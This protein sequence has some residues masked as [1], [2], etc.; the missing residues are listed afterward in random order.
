[1]GLLCSEQEITEEIMQ[2]KWGFEQLPS[3]L[4][5]L[6]EAMSRCPGAHAAEIEAAIDTLGREPNGGLIAFRTPAMVLVARVP[7]TDRVLV[8]LLL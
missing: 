4:A 5:H 2:M 3:W 6:R 8:S 7:P 1:M